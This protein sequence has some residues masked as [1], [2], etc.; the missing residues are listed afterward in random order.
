MAAQKATDLR[1][2]LTEV[3]SHRVELR[4]RQAELEK[5]LLSLPSHSWLEVGEKA[6]YL[7]GLFAET[8]IAQDPRRQRLIESVLDDIRHL[9]ADSQDLGGS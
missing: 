2:R 1:R 9:S 7:L 4:Q 5:F 3:E 6:R 8:S